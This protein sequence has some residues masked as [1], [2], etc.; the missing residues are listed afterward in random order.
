MAVPGKEST[1][2]GH[3]LALLFWAHFLLCNQQLTL[4]VF[5]LCHGRVWATSYERSA[6]STHQETTLA[7]AYHSDIQVHHSSL[8]LLALKMKGSK[9]GKSNARNSISALEDSIK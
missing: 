4:A 2:P 6:Q 3:E 5:L 8:L 7:T 9:E 1:L